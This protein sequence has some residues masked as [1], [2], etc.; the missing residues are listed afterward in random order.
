MRICDSKAFNPLS[1]TEFLGECH[2]STEQTLM[3]NPD[4]SRK[5][6]WLGSGDKTHFFYYYNFFFFAFYVLKAIKWV[7][8]TLKTIS[9]T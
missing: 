7:T 1:L 8:K 2:Q 3:K 6:P 4:E 5:E 9:M